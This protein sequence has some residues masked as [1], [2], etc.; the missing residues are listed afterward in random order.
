MV[1]SPADYIL[2]IFQT[3]EQYF[4]HLRRLSS[5]VKHLEINGIW[6]LANVHTVESIWVSNGDTFAWK[7]SALRVRLHFFHL[8]LAVYDGSQPP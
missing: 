4:T 2:P 3:T 5:E 7:K 1:S 6:W 8:D